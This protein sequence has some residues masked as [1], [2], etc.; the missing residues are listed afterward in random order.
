MANDA[1]KISNTTIATT[2]LSTD[3]VVVIANATTTANVQTITL[4][5]LANS[6]MIAWFKSLPTT[7]PNTTNQPWNNGGS[8]SFT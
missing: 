1:Q 3:R 2:L 4:A 5:N 7:L 8:L 6:M